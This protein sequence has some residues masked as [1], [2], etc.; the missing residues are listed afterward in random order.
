MEA[1]KGTA[2]VL[3]VESDPAVLK[4][5]AT[6][7]K[8]WLKARVVAATDGEQGLELARE[9]K[10]NLVITAIRLKELD[11]YEV[12]RRLKA[13]PQTESIPLVAL[14]S[15]P[16]NIVLA[17]GFDDHVFKPFEVLHLVRTVNTY[18]NSEPAS[19]G[20]VEVASRPTPRADLLLL[21]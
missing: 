19:G 13:D 15:E 12:A 21:N 20:T 11:G 3:V 5:V 18:V 8:L 9:L 10:P 16:R 17:A 6:I 7:F 2:L 1:G 4:L 14:T